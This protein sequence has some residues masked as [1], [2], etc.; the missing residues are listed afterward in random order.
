ML[1]QVAIS[2]GI[3]TYNNAKTIGETIRSLKEQTFREWECY[4]CD[5]S[6]SNETFDAALLA[7]SDDQRFTLIKN[8]VRLGAA[9]NWNKTLSLS[10]SSYFKLLCADDVIFPDTLQIQWQALEDNPKSVLCTGRRNII[11]ESGRLII[12]DRGLNSK[13][14]F[15]PYELVVKRFL[16]TGSNF[17]G[18]PSFALYRTQELREAGGFNPDWSYL[19]DVVSYLGIL[20]YGGLSPVNETLGSFRISSN[21]WS[22][23]LSKQQRKENLKC[24]EYAA[25]LDFVSATLFELFIGKLRATV[26]S[27]VRR[28]IFKFLG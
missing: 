15:M 25:S 5:D 8:K 10:Q 9:G 20:K 27:Y 1:N 16:R 26:S 12:K 21:S 19:I 24:I 3:P 2:I 7:I 14:Y 28:A 18:E 17:F 4:I 11:N 23:N 13:I 6:E 22:A